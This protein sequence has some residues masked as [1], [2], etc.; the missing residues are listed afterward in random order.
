MGGGGDGGL[1][2]YHL[3]HTN[4]NRPPFPIFSVSSNTYGTACSPVSSPVAINGPP[5]APTVGTATSTAA[6]S[7]TLGFTASAVLGTPPIS[8]YTVKCVNLGKYE[9]S[10]AVRKKSG[11]QKLKQRLTFDQSVLNPPLNS[12][13]PVAHVRVHGRRRCDHDRAVQCV[14]AAR[15]R[16]W[17][18]EQ[19]QRDVLRGGQQRCGAGRHLLR[20][21]QHRGHAGS[22]ERADG[23]D[24]GFDGH[25]PADGAVYGADQVSEVEMVGLGKVWWRERGGVDEAELRGEDGA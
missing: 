19:C 20:R 21:Q 1:I 7:V 17:F 6:G 10:F 13:H 14:A 15:D 23:G 18:P 25:G 2:F 5:S 8:Q 22:A 3:T 24:A 4:K 12:R 9:Y 11:T 16:H